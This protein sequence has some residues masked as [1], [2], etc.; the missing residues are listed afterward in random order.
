MRSYD[1]SI[2]DWWDIEHSLSLG[3]EY[4]ETLAVPLPDDD[5]EKRGENSKF[6]KSA[7]KA[8]VRAISWLIVAGKKTH[9]MEMLS[10]ESIQSLRRKSEKYRIRTKKKDSKREETNCNSGKKK[11]LTYEYNN[12]LTSDRRE[13]LLKEF[14]FSCCELEAVEMERKL[15]N[16]EY[17]HWTRA[18]RNS[19][20]LF[21]Q[22]CLADVTEIDADGLPSTSTRHE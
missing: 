3:W 20:P 7:R 13:E 5:D 14:G 2:G 21:L 18:S 19:S 16:F 1:R 4:I 10:A 11:S 6:K 9:T 12:R 22:R 17:S 15:L 8:K